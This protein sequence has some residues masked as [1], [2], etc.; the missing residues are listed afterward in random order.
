[1][2]A[3]VYEPISSVLKNSFYGHGGAKN[4]SLDSKM[5]STLQKSMLVSVHFDDPVKQSPSLTPKQKCKYTI[6]NPKNDAAADNNGHPG[7]PN[8]TS[9]IKLDQVPEPKMTLFRREQVELG[10]R[11]PAGPGAGMFNMGNTCYLNSTLQALFHT[12]AFV[13]Y[14]RFGGH[15]NSCGSNG[16]SSCTI[17]IMAATLRGTTNANAMKPI[18]IYEKLKLICKHLTHG[19]QEDA[20][21]FLR[22][23]VESLQ[24]SYL[25]SRKVPKTVDTYTKETTPFNQIFG[26]YMR[27]DVVCMRCRH[28]ST[29]FQHFMDLLLDIR[30]ADNI[31]TA[32]G[33]YFKR[34]NLGQGE[35][36]YKCEKCKQKVPATKQYKIERPPLVLCIQLKRFNLMGGKNGRPVTLA[37][38]I[39][40]S[41]HV[42]W[43]PQHNIPV[44]YKL[45]SMIN[46]VGP[47]PNCGHYT[48]IGEAA[49]GTFYRF[50]DATVHPTSLQ[51][52]LNT[53]AYVIFYEMLKT[54]KSLILSPKTEQ[55]KPKLEVTPK[56]SPKSY[57]NG[58]SEKKLIGPLLPPEVKKS[59][60]PKPGPSP[61]LIQDT[62][63]IKPKLA[64]SLQIKPKLISEPQKKTLVKPAVKPSVKP[65]QPM[66][67]L[68]PYDGGSSSEDETPQKPSKPAPQP[69]VPKV[70]PAPG[71]PK[72]MPVISSSPFLPRSVVVNFK[73]IKEVQKDESD[74]T[75]SANVVDSKSNQP[76][77]SDQ[78]ACSQ[79]SPVS[80]KPDDSSSK[81][82]ASDKPNRDPSSEALFAKSLTNSTKEETPKTIA[83]RT[84]QSKNEFVVTDLEAHNPSIHS[85]NSTGST[86]SFSVS[87]IGSSRNG[88][89]SSS[90]DVS[91]TSRQKWSVT[92]NNCKES[93]STLKTKS[94][95]HGTPG[96]ISSSSKRERSVPPKLAVS[97]KV[98]EGNFASDTELM[99][100][101]KKRKKTALFERS[102]LLEKAAEIGKDVWNA[103]T[104][105]GMNL[106]KS[107][108]PGK[109]MNGDHK[110]DFESESVTSC[111]ATTSYQDEKPT[112]SS[113]TSKPEATADADDENEEDFHHTKK[114]KKKKKKHKKKHEDNSDTE[115][116]VEKTRDNLDKFDAKKLKKDQRT[117]SPE[118]KR[119]VKESSSNPDAPVKKWDARPELKTIGR[120]VTWDGSKGSN[121]VEE[122]M[123]GSEIRSWSGDRSAL[124]R[125]SAAEPRK[126]SAGD[127]LDAEM[128]AGRVKKV[129]KHREEPQAYKWDRNPFQ[130]AQNI[131]NRGDKDKFYEG[132][133]SLERNRSEDSQRN[134]S[135]VRDKPR[136]NDHKDRYSGHK[137]RYS[138]K[139][140]FNDPKDRY[141][142]NDRYDGEKDRHS[143]YD[144]HNAP[145]DRYNGAN[146]HDQQHDHRR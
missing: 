56:V 65:V 37:K 55:G 12:P 38:K 9:S 127:D 36:M 104:K 47:S 13:N 139:P 140:R 98:S 75:K 115:G 88:A 99:G 22:Y 93:V 46:H 141:N 132:H 54:S 107:S 57:Q 137:D 21:E 110:V 124:E 91:V 72:S 33:G 135:W 108:K 126:R 16:F 94:L 133:H 40:I 50:D 39:N 61:K 32:L 97:E 6:L 86:T 119:N 73:K 100:S 60:S 63:P 15:E 123:K 131:T 62:P 79:S 81:S 80:S 34:E 58:Q 53:S 112:S 23:L 84:P 8:K 95:P 83:P 113:T 85:D 103:G 3:S 136:Y 48:S 70:D 29:T 11:A 92:P 138:D 10:Y 146:G 129:K 26:G 76:M 45:V 31:D 35:N 64:P 145:K 43:A 25:I 59:S 27:Q 2:P 120:S 51:N 87:D 44:E 118:F 66:Q 143:R 18:K 24:K 42:R 106:F 114:H 7:T 96:T 69:A 78:P 122:L 121:V 125:K 109:G 68:V 19:R 102:N 111:E 128:D 130:I 52:A 5:D 1:M 90:T 67:G 74:G 142:S 28:V 20:H 41:N 30:Q 17:C 71:G 144:R 89:G 49:N 117:K 14:L 101:P 4:S 77:K 134:E 105:L 116:W 82:S